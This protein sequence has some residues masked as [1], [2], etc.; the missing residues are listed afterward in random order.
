MR[1]ALI[2]GIDN[3]PSHPLNGCVSDAEKM[4]EILSKNSDGSPNFHC[5]LVSNITSKSHL[6]S[7]VIDLFTRQSDISLFYFSGYAGIDDLCGYLITPDMAV[8]DLGLPFPQL[9]SIVNNSPSKEK[10]IILDTVNA[11]GTGI[12]NSS[13]SFQYDANTYIREGTTILANMNNMVIPIETNSGRVLTSL[14]HT[15]LTGAAANLQGNVSIVSTFAFISN[16][17][18]PW[19][20]QPLFKSNTTT[21]SSLRKCNPKI[22]FELLRQL[23]ILFPAIH[24]EYFLD[25]SYEFTSEVGDS[26]NSKT[27][28]ILQ[29]FSAL[30][31]VAPVGEEYMYWAAMNSKSCKLTPVG[32]LYWKLIKNG[33]I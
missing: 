25:P 23:I 33:R 24:S 26:E 31:L 1:R 21:A 9:L 20:Q 27:F 18:G 19:N 29:R 3:Y 12:G 32:Q 30:D 8:Y 13:F 4:Y 15:A 2:I 5:E 16:I 10:I 17:L 6:T 22:E 11:A 28:K 14:I 7:L